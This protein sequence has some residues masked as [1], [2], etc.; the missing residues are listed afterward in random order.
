VI[1][2]CGIANENEGMKPAKSMTV[3]LSADQAELLETV[4]SVEERPVSEVIRLAIDE[5]IARRRN[6]AA[7]QEG[8]KSRIERAQ[9]FLAD[10]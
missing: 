2:S 9:R 1:D 3:R 6:D 4:A 8:L 5:H 10:S 7:F